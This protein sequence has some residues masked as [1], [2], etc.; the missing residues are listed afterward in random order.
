MF[1]LLICCSCS[2]G[3]SN[4]TS[5][6][7]VDSAL[8][9]ASLGQDAVLGP[10]GMTLG[11]EIGLVMMVGFQGRLSDT[12]LEDWQTHQFGG[13]IVVP[14]NQ[15]AVDPGGIRQLIQTVRGVLRQP[16]LAATNQEGLRDASDPVIDGDIAPV[17]AR[18][19]R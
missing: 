6:P 8:Q 18:S 15:N 1:G 16:L 12:V 2:S 13:L 3:A 19:D 9:T 11:D 17:S 10:A 7:S 14:V 5:G 4:M